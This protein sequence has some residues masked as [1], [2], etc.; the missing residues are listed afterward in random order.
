MVNSHA[1]PAAQTTDTA[2]LPASLP[3]RVKECEEAFAIGRQI[4]SFV[5]SESTNVNVSRE[6]VFD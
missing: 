2:S 6:H 5:M 1:R 3:L 4:F